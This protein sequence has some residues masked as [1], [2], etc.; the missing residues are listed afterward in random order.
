MTDITA[1]SSLNLTLIANQTL[2]VVGF[3]DVTIDNAGHTSVSGEG[4]F[5]PFDKI[6]SI[7]ILALTNCEYFE[8]TPEFIKSFAQTGRIDSA[9]YSASGNIISATIDGYPYAATED[10]NG[11]IETTEFLGITKTYE[12]EVMADGEYHIASITVN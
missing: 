11:N 10:A 2:R 3:A 4:V 8:S 1:G 9:V 6:S 7:K 5:G 12:W